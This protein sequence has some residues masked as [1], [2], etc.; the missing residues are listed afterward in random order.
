MGLYSTHHDQCQR[1][2]GVTAI[3]VES[4]G[5][6]EGHILDLEST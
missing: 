5:V 1:Q 3:V 2:R 6:G 4:G